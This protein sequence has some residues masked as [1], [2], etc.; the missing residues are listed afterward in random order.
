MPK[1]G[2]NNTQAAK[3][4][5]LGAQPNPARQTSCYLLPVFRQL[6]VVAI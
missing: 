3:P 5:L 6:S 2:L 1:N 4:L